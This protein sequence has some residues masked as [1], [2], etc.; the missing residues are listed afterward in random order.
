MDETKIDL[1]LSSFGHNNFADRAISFANNLPDRIY[2][3][4]HSVGFESFLYF[5][6]A[7]AT[8]LALAVADVLCLYIRPQ[9][10]ENYIY[11]DKSAVTEVHAPPRE[12]KSAR[13]QEILEH[14]TKENMS[15]WK[16]A[17]LEAD[18]ILDELTKDLNLPGDNLGERLKSATPANM[19]TLEDAWSAHKLR[20]EIAHGGADLKLHK[21]QV[22]EAISAFERVFREFDYI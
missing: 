13:W 1:G 6:W 4:M 10:E 16:I 12:K 15:D 19:R 14:L 9:G 21:N 8:V 22:T 18:T 7:L 11:Y 3:F 17:V 20:N 2:A 5:L